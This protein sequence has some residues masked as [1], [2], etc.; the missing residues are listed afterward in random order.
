M[1]ANPTEDEGSI[2]A[3]EVKGDFVRSG[4]IFNG[5]EEEIEDHPTQKK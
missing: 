2:A 3:A 5:L 4:C 1:A